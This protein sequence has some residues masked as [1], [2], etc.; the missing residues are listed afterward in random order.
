[1]VNS[2]LYGCVCSLEESDYL[3]HKRTFWWL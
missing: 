2:V 3:D 1:M